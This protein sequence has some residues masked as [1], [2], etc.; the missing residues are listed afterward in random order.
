MIQEHIGNMSKNLR[1]LV[2]KNSFK[3][4]YK[5]AQSYLVK[6]KSLVDDVRLQHLICDEVYF[7]RNGFPFSATT[8]STG[9][10]LVD[11]QR[12]QTTGV[13]SY[14]GSRY[15]LL[16]RRRGIW[17]RLRKSSNYVPKGKFLVP[18]ISLNLILKCSRNSEEACFFVADSTFYLENAPL[19]M[20]LLV[21]LSLIHTM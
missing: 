4:R 20:R 18:I 14:T 10:L 19:K 12:R 6:L 16:D 17:Q 1:A 9:R 15:Y 5:T 13:S 7:L 11:Y 21:E 2:T 8:R 3:E